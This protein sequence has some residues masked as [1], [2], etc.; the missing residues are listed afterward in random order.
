M[1]PKDLDPLART[2]NIS[3]I[4]RPKA[5]PYLVTSKEHIQGM[6]LTFVSGFATGALVALIFIGSRVT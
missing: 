3:E 2:R 4:K 5:R 1:D 6:F